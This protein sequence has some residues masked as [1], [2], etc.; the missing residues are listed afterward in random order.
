MNY[1][2]DINEIKGFILIKYGRIYDPFLKIDKVQD[3]L[4]KDGIIIKINS[5]I[6]E[7]SNYKVLKCKN[8]IITNGFIDLH[9]HFREPGFEFK[10]TIST[11]SRSAFYGGYTRV[12]V[13]PNTNPVIDNPELI[14]YLKDKSEKMPIYLYPIGAITKGQKGKELAEIGLMVDAGAVAISDDGVPVNNSQILRMAI[15]YAKKFNIP[16]INH[17]EDSFLV[18]HGLINE[19]Q[20]SLK[21]GL[22]GNPDISE[23]TMIFR[24][25]SIAEYISGSLHIPHVSSSKSVEIIKHFK[26]KGVKVTSEVTPHH[27]CLTD[28]ILKNYDTNAKVAPPI[29][30]KVDKNALISAVKA[31]IIDCIATD[32]APHAIEDK[33]KDMHHAP[34]GMIGLESAFGLVNKTLKKTKMSTKSI[35]DLFTINPS[36]IL[37]I[38]PDTI[39]EGNIAEINIIN[40]DCRWVFEKHNIKSKSMNTPIL[41][42]ELVGKVVVT[43]NK[44]FIS[45]CKSSK[46]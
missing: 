27:L 39:K 45:N 7:K 12:C 4:I 46:S 43:I 33:E 3:I 17:A 28:D 9:S 31:G 15:E 5:N 2:N 16:V 29:R 19:G 18:N 21:L 13:M 14:K 42:M 44:G 40:P 41:G 10:E 36:K 34:C 23:S 37:N 11:G 1:D 25:L 20:N 26:E 38:K 24:D 32:H 22:T 6:P 30:S 8:E 35:I